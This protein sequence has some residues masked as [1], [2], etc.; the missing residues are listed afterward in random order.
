[1]KQWILVLA[2][3]CMAAVP[4]YSAAEGGHLIGG[5]AKSPIRIEVFSDFECPYCREF[6]LFVIR[7]VLQ[8]YSSKDLVSVVYFEF[9]LPSH[10]YSKEA[11]RYSEAAS[12]VG[13]NT[14]LKV[15]EALYREQLDWKKT[16]KL[17]PVVAKVLTPD[18]MKKL[19]QFMTDPGINAAIEKDFQTGS[20]LGVDG[21][22]TMFIYF[23]PGKQQ[24]V[25]MKN[26]PLVY[27]TVRKFLDKH[28]K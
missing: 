26:G 23:P 16:G 13:Q 19:K 14:L 27:D 6:Y 21:T 5:S 28:L 20:A 10:T 22:P 15:Q 9:P 17:E 25:E 4:G 18:E 7:Q 12:R 1:M 11:A 24:K 3:L 2:V 8:N